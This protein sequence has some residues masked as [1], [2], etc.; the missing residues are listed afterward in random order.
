MNTL[1]AKSNRRAAAI[2]AM[3][4]ALSL[5]A[6]TVAPK[7]AEAVVGLALNVP[8]ALVIAGIAGT[9]GLTGFLATVGMAVGMGPGAD[10][11]EPFPTLYAC[12]A[13]GMLGGVILLEGPKGPA[14]RFVPMTDEQAGK[15]GLSREQQ[16]AFN[17][18]VD[19][20]NGVAET[21]GSELSAQ[22]SPSVG[23]SQALWAKYGSALGEE[24]LEAV[25]KVSAAALQASE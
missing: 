17:D 1:I 20:I 15:V 6:N 2:T 11:Q 16:V 24:T 13:L 22:P 5:T 12:E 21:I 18:N 9:L 23:A 19:E 7:R 10:E 4:V 14:V 25:A 8:A 3:A